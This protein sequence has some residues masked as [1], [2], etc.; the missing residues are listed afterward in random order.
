MKINSVFPTALQLRAKTPSLTEH[1]KAWHTCL[2]RECLSFSSS[3]WKL[4]LSRTLLVPSHQVSFCSDAS[5][6]KSPSP[7]SLLIPC[8]SFSPQLAPLSPNVLGMCFSVFSYQKNKRAGVVFSLVLSALLRLMPAHV[9]TR[10]LTP[11]KELQVCVY[12]L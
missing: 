7:H 6:Q 12:S 8:A 1:F 4:L 9:S 11:Q 2:Q 3:C 10:V 5:A